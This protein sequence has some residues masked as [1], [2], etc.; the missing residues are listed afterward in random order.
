MHLSHRDL[1]GMLCNA[2]PLRTRHEN[3]NTTSP[4]FTHVNK[5]G[6]PNFQLVLV[7]KAG[8]GVDKRRPHLLFLASTPEMDP[9]PGPGQRHGAVAEWTPLE[10]QNSTLHLSLF[11]FTSSSQSVVVLFPLLLKGGT[12]LSIHKILIWDGI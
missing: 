9:G 6:H 1:R 3:I 5:Q 7:L 2:A 4:H 10:T 12:H 8:N 11:F